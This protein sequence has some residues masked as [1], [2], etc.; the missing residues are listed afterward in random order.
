LRY[1]HP[2]IFTLDNSCLLHKLF[3]FIFSAREHFTDTDLFPFKQGAVLDRHIYFYMILFSKS[4]VNLSVPICFKCREMVQER[5]TFNVMMKSEAIH[6]PTSSVL[7][8]AWSKSAA[9]NHGMHNTG[10]NRRDTTGSTLFS[11]C[12][13]E[14]FM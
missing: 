4:K 1:Y 11:K 9:N 6:T 7:R 10:N 8:S 13:I 3:H 12:N 5:F 14:S 2:P